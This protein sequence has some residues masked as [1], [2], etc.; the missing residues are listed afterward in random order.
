MLRA[1]IFD[2]DGVLID[3]EPL[4]KIAEQEVFSKVGIRLNDEMCALTTGLE[5]QDTVK[6]W[7]DRHPW[8]EP[9]VDDICDDI[10]KKVAQLIQEKGKAI[11]GVQETLAFFKAKEWPIAVASSSSMFLIRTTLKKLNIETYFEVVHSSEY[12]KAGKPNPAVYLGAARKLGIEPHECLAIEDSFRGVEA[13]HHAGMKVIAVPDS[14][15]KGN[16][17]F[18]KAD[19]VLDSLSEI[20][21]N[22][23]N[24][25][26]I[27]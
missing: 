2:M 27:I 7:F 4:W 26:E 16:Q 9:S 10:E 21:E 25:L 19:L 17:G 22:T 20:N 11:T 3:S 14:H 1:V 6:F 12:E 5:I 15:L 24:R 13:A 18:N 8:E 23:L